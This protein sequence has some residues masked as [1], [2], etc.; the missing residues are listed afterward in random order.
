MSMRSVLKDAG[1]KISVND[2]VIRAAALALR[3]TPSVNSSFNPTTGAVEASSTV[4]VSVAVAT[5]GGL[6]TPI[7]RDA[8]SRGL[9]DINS[10][11]KE[12]AGRAR[13]GKLKPEE[14]QGGSFT[15]SN[16][17]MF[18]IDKFTAVINPPQSAILA[19]GQGRKILVPDLNS[20]PGSESGPKEVTEMIVTLSA[21]RRVVDSAAAGQFLASFRQYVEN[22]TLLNA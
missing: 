19:V 5:E 7:V 9:A 15:I 2:V 21:D 12:L 4:D 6:I 16:L 11:V 20:T 10:C 13:A 8:V 22:P 1:V 14:F 3:D 17:G 18:G